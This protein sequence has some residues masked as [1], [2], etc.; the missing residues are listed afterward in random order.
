MW[1]DGAPPQ[2][3]VPHMMISDAVPTPALS[4]HIPLLGKKLEVVH[5]AEI[6]STWMI[7]SAVGDVDDGRVA[8]TGDVYPKWKTECPERF[9][10]FD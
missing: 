3:V 5:P 10:R 4:G 6:Q 1:G 9:D 2:A 7:N 8:G